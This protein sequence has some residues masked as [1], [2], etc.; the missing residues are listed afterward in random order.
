VDVKLPIVDHSDPTIDP[1]KI[2]LELLN[3]YNL[4]AALYKHNGIWWVRHS[5]QIYNDDTDFVVA[6]NVFEEICQQIN[7]KRAAKGDC[8]TT[9]NGTLVSSETACNNKDSTK[10][11]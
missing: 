9:Q 1:S 6:G 3:K 11:R 8:E 4:Y 10:Q 7:T 2:Q 5:A